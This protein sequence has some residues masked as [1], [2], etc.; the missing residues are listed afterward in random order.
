MPQSL[1]HNPRTKPLEGCPRLAIS[2]LWG[3][4]ISLE[5]VSAISSF[6]TGVGGRPHTARGSAQYSRQPHVLILRSA[7]GRTGC[8]PWT[9]RKTTL[10]AVMNSSINTSLRVARMCRKMCMTAGKG[11]RIGFGVMRFARCKAHRLY[12]NLG[13]G[14]RQIGP[15]E[16]ASVKWPRLRWGVCRRR[17]FF[18]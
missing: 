5:R 13:Q 15:R 16:A 7:D 11:L 1:I 14:G 8:R 18:C 2:A 12:Q 6:K 17:R 3:R 10:F 4:I 9:A